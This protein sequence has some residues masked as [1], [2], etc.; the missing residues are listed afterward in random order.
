MRS[1]NRVV[2]RT[3]TKSNQKRTFAS[4]RNDN[5]PLAW[6]DW[7]TD[8]FVIIHKPSGLLNVRKVNK[9][10]F[11]CKAKTQDLIL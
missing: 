3:C 2:C 4:L 10:G 9:K 7:K 5:V 11:K 8:P 6:G 1:I